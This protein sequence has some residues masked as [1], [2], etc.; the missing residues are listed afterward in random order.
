VQISWNDEPRSSP[1]DGPQQPAAGGTAGPGGPGGP[2]GYPPPP[3]PPPPGAQPGYYGQPQWGYGPPPRRGTNGLAIASLVCGIVWIYGITSV[4]AIIFGLVA[5]RQ[6][7]ERNETG[8]GMAIAGIVL[9]ILG[10]IGAIIVVIII[11]TVVDDIE[12]YE[13]FQDFNMIRAAA[14]YVKGSLVGLL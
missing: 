10:V 2:G 1:G 5:R 14:L 3:P 13:D 9:G 8:D 6:I 7:K 12:D 11:A 4:L